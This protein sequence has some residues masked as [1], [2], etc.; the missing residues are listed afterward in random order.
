MCEDEQS[1]TALLG[2]VKYE[3]DEEGHKAE[4]EFE[5]IKRFKLSAEGILDSMFQRPDS[6]TAAVSH[7]IRCA[8]SGTTLMLNSSVKR[9]AC[10]LL[11]PSCRHRRRFDVERALSSSSC[12]KLTFELSSLII[13]ESARH[14]KRNNPVF[15]EMV[16]H[17]F[18][19]VCV[20]RR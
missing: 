17:K 9:L 5:E 19:D 18:G 10:V 7:T 14:P 1:K 15:E 8:W 2:C 4:V 12:L 20:V 13:N 16:P 11:A 6:V 3:V